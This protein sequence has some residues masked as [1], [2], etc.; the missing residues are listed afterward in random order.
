MLFTESEME[1]QRNLSESTEK[2]KVVVF[3]NNGEV[4][5]VEIRTVQNIVKVLKKAVE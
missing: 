5:G 4:G 1:S 3:G 2:I